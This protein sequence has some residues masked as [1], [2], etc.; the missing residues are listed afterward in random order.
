MTT[1]ALRTAVTGA[2]AEKPKDIFG[3]LRVYSSEIARALPRHMTADRMARIVTTEIRRMPKLLACE[4]KS[5]FGAVIQ[6]S[7]LGLEP[8]GG[9]GHAYLIP[10]GKECQLIIGY[11][12]MIDLARRSGQMISLTGEAVYAKDKFEYELGLEP[13]LKHVPST[14]ADRGELT[15]AYAVACLTGG[16][17]QFVVLSRSDVERI[18]KRSKAAHSGPWVT[19]YDAMAVKTAIRRLFKYLPVSVELQRAVVLDEAADRGEQHNASVLDGE[20]LVTTDDAPQEQEPE[21]T[22]ARPA[23]ELDGNAPAVTWAS[24]MEMINRSDTFEVLDLAREMIAAV[25]DEQQRAELDVA[26][27]KRRKELTK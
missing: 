1:A 16:G 3:M 13:R 26:E 22:D 25:D 27:R 5:L 15:Y 12:G 19:D 24:V 6:C 21:K 9:L 7:Q 23:L 4:A 10:Y 17:R 2:P 18:K 11:R 20:Y 14:D 8:G